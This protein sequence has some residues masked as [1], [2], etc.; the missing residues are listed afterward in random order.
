MKGIIA[1]CVLFLSSAMSASSVD[2]HTFKSAFAV[3]DVELDT[4]PLSTFWQGRPRSTQRLIVGAIELPLIELR[5]ARD[6]QRTISISCS[7]VFAGTRSSSFRHKG[8][9]LTWMSISIFLITP[10]GGPGTPGF[11]L[12]HAP[13]PKQEPGMAPCAF[14]SLRS[15]AA[16]RPSAERFARTCSAARG[17]RSDGWP[18]PGRL[19]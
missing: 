2:G 5:S 10:W 12:P 15:I 3:S 1:S 14:P 4:N 17:L 16:R 7:C 6:G 13:M 18:S 11:R 9:G 8:S 19:Q